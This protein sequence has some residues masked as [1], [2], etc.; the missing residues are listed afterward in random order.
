MVMYDKAQ[1]E[2][3]ALGEDGPLDLAAASD[4]TWVDLTILPAQFH[5]PAATPAHGRPEAAL[6]RAVLEDAVQCICEGWLSQHRA[7]RRLGREALEWLFS[8]DG[9]WPFSFVNICTLLGLEPEY[10]RRGL[11]HW[12][13]QPA[14]LG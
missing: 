6:M 2:G 12:V 14:P 13:Q 4:P 10:L 7:K 3:A 8:E 11:R 5:P 9:Q 1:E